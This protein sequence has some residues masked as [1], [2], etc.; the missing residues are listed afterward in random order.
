[1]S[2]SRKII[3]RLQCS[4]AGINGKASQHQLNGDFDHAAHQDQPQGNEAGFCTQ[5]CRSNEFARTN[6]AGSHDQS[7]APVTKHAT[8]LAW[9]ILNTCGFAGLCL[10]W[11]H[12]DWGESCAVVKSF[13]VDGHHDRQR[14]L[15]CGCSC[16]EYQIGSKLPPTFD[17]RNNFAGANLLPNPISGRSAAEQGC[18]C[19]TSL[20]EKGRATA[21]SQCRFSFKDS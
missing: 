13:H 9:R 21:S 2:R 16:L 19:P 18:S 5:A 12:S 7:R 4:F 17:N 20:A 6:H 14:K 8:Q 1:M 15:I 10:F 11:R 3:E